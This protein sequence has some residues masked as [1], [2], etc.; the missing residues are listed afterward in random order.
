MPRHSEKSMI[1]DAISLRKCI[2]RKREPTN[3]ATFIWSIRIVGPSRSRQL[4]SANIS[5][6]EK[7]LLHTGLQRLSSLND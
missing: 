5:Q 6:F 2:P 4:L 3:D 7:L 1:E